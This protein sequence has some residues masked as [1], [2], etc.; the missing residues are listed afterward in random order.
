MTPSGIEH[1]NFQ[2]VAHCFNQLRRHFPH[3]KADWISHIQRRTC[4]LKHII[5]EGLEVMG[6][7]QGRRKQLLDYLKETRIYS[8]LKAEALDRTL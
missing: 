2:L 5:G 3:C 1:A 6:R 4:L 8:K 7:R